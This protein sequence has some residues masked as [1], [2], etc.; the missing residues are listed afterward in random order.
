MF[1]GPTRLAI[2]AAA[3][4]F[5]AIGLAVA[6]FGMGLPVIVGAFLAAATVGVVQYA[7]QRA[8]PAPDRS[9][10]AALTA[11]IATLRTTNASLRHDLRGVLSPALM[12]SDR[13]LNHAD[14]AVQKAGQVVVRSIDRATALLSASKDSQAG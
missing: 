11:E 8:Q 10:E 14:P 5:G 2:L 3:L 13:L 7:A 1:H 9:G 4:S 6:L 12:M